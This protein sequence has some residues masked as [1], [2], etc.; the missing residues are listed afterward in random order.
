MTKAFDDR[1]R[2]GYD[3]GLS[4]ENEIYDGGSVASMRVEA[5][6]PRFARPFIAKHHYTKTFPDSTL[7]TFAGWIGDALAG[8]IT[9]GMGV[10][11]NQ[12]KALIPDIKRGEYLEL[13]R[14]WSPDG[15]PKNTESRL[16]GA[17]IRM[18]PPKVR[19]LISFADSSRGHTG[20][21]YQATNFYHLGMTNGGKMLVTED[22]IEKHPRL[23]GIYRMRHA[24]YANTPT[25][26]LMSILGY[27]YKEAGAKHRY[28]LPIAGK[29]NQRKKDRATLSGIATAQKNADAPFETPAPPNPLET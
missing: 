8:V 1:A 22:G 9:F 2:K 11:L 15:M 5:V 3:D 13:T 10:G 16:I 21:I 12:Y 27:S 7:H 29:K 19:L 6:S 18:L 28:A 23:L 24:E 20:T 17:A 25:P 14:L 26:E 4:P